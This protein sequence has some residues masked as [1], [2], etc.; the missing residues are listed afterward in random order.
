MSQQIKKVKKTISRVVLFTEE[1]ITDEFA[2]PLKRG[3]FVFLDLNATAN[4]GDLVAVKGSEYPG[5]RLEYYTPG[6]NYFAVGIGVGKR[7]NKKGELMA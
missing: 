7:L 2:P 3:E 5:Y 6:V 1:L 4:P